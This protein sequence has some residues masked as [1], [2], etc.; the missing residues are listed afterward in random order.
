MNILQIKPTSITLTKEQQEKCGS[1]CLAYINPYSI[2]V[3]TCGTRIE[4]D[5]VFP[6]RNPTITS[7]TDLHNGVV[8]VRGQ[9]AQQPVIALSNKELLTT[10]KL[11]EFC[12]KSKQED[13]KTLYTDCK[14]VKLLLQS[15]DIIIGK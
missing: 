5:N 4:C 13:G 14:H 9:I 12:A 7:L 1:D 11:F 3:T 15:K 6:Q 10:Q 8:E 2:H